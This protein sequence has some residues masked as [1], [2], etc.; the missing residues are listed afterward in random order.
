M[1]QQES[2][3]PLTGKHDSY[4][5]GASR[6]RSTKHWD[7]VLDDP[8]YDFLGSSA[9]GFMR[10]A[11]SVHGGELETFRLWLLRRHSHWLLDRIPDEGLT[12]VQETLKDIH[13]FYRSR[14]ETSWYP[15]VERSVLVN[16]IRSYDR[17]EFPLAGD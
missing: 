17:P 6:T 5:G 11:F 4:S 12:E 7:L 9:R 8:A 1:Q 15:P 2:S 14:P 16:H 13:E 3:T 10:R